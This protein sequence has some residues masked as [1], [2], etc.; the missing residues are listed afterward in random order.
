[1]EKANIKDFK[2]CIY[3]FVVL[4]LGT[5]D[6][7]SLTILS[8]ITICK[9]VRPDYLRFC[10]SLKSS[11]NLNGALFKNKNEEQEPLLQIEVNKCINNYNNTKQICILTSNI[12]KILYF[13]NFMDQI[14]F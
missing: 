11:I 3:Y 2:M 7:Y 1:M 14:N 4:P 12:T 6:L 10:K 13:K 8:L 9:M 5:K